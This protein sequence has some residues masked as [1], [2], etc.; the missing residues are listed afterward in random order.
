MRDYYIFADQ[1]PIVNPAD[2]PDASA[3]L[4]DLRVDPDV[5]SGIGPQAAR[6]NLF[7]EG[8]I[9]GYGLR[10]RRDAQNDLRF[11]SISAGSPMDA[12][13]ALRGDRVIALNGIAEMTITAETLNEIFGP[14][15][16]LQ[17]V[18]FTIATG[19]E[20]PRDIVV[21]PAIYI[22]DTV[23]NVTTFDVNGNKVGYIESNIFLRTSETQLDAAVRTM[24]AEN[25]SDVVLDFRY[26]GGGYVYIAQKLASQ[27]LGPDFVG[28][29]FQTMSFNERYSQFNRTSVY[30]AQELNLSLP[31]IIILT[32]NDTASASE[33]I[34]NSLRPYIDVVMIG[35]RTRGKPFASVGNPN[36]EL[37]LNAMDR[38]AS[39]QVGETVLGG[40]IPTCAVTDTFQFLKSS[41][42]DALMGAALDYLATGACPQQ[43]AAF[44]FN[45]SSGRSSTVQAPID[46]FAETEL[47]GGMLDESFNGIG[48]R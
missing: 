30:E 47:P 13:G 40:L 14:A 29:P 10:W 4:D 11:V 46:N 39:N 23:P 24:M 41:P 9:F 12:A 32:T 22:L 16:D 20:E 38:I 2:Y 1:V 27:I 19:S 15:D 34:A 5:F 37:V 17:P 43:S 36:C 26:N 21:A 25:P 42:N 8:E 44:G 35:S 6:D 18:R 28:Q 48:R 45:D 33:A 3:L 31:R 7:E